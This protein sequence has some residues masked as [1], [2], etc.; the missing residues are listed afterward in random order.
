MNFMKI[1][2]ENMKLVCFSKGHTMKFHEI[3]EFGWVE[4]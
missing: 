3:H 4:D 1:S 2:A